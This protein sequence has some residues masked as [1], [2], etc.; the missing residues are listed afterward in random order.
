MVLPLRYRLPA[1]AHGL[2]YCSIALA[3]QQVLNGIRLFDRKLSGFVASDIVSPFIR[4]IVLLVLFTLKAYKYL[5]NTAN[6][7][8]YVSKK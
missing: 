2:G 6:I 8:R 5:Y 1:H 4:N 3:L 7:P